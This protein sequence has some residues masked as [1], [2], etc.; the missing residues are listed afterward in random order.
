[1][2]ILSIIFL[3]E[4]VAVPVDAFEADLPLL[5]RR[6]QMTPDG[7]RI[8]LTAESSGCCRLPTPRTVRV[9]VDL[10]DD[11]QAGRTYWM[12]AQ[13][14]ENWRA[15][16]TLGLTDGL[17]SGDLS[18]PSGALGEPA[19][20]V[21]ANLFRRL[22]ATRS[23]EGRLS[24]QELIRAFLEDH[25]PDKDTRLGCILINLSLLKVRNDWYNAL[26]LLPWEALTEPERPAPLQ[27][28]RPIVIVRTIAA[29]PYQPPEELNL[30]QPAPMLALLPRKAITPEIRAAERRARPYAPRRHRQELVWCD[31]PKPRPGVRRAH[32]RK[33]FERH[34]PAALHY[35]G[36]GA[37]WPHDPGQLVSALQIDDALLG[38]LELATQAHHCPIWLFSCFAC[39]S[40]TPGDQSE[41][42]LTSE[43]W[44]IINTF[45]SSVPAML[46]MTISISTTAA[47]VAGEAWYAALAGGA[48]LLQAAHQM[49]RALWEHALQ[50]QGRWFGDR[51]AWWI[52]AL[53]LRHPCWDRALVNHT[54]WKQ[55]LQPP[56][57]S[58][59]PTRDQ[60]EQIKA[61]F[62]RLEHSRY[63]VVNVHGRTPQTSRT[64]LLHQIAERLRAERKGHLLLSAPGD[65]QAGGIERL[66]M[67]KNVIITRLRQARGLHAHW[68]G[69][70]LKRAMFD[71]PTAEELHRRY[72]KALKAHRQKPFWVLIDDIDR[73]V[74][75]QS[76]DGREPFP[77]LS[78][79][80]LHEC[81]ET[82]VRFIVTTQN[83]EFGRQ[84][85]I[86][87]LKLETDETLSIPRLFTQPR[88]YLHS[89][90]AFMEWYRERKEHLSSR[91]LAM[92]LIADQA[93]H[94]TTMH[95][96]C[97]MKELGERAD[98]AR[99]LEHLESEELAAR[100][101]QRCQAR[102]D[103]ALVEHWAGDQATAGIR[104]D[105]R[106]WFRRWYDQVARETLRKQHN[107]LPEDLFRLILK[108]SLFE[109]PSGCEIA[110]YNYGGTA[111][112]DNALYRWWLI[113]LE[114]A[115][116]YGLKSSLAD[117]VAD[118]ARSDV[119]Y[120]ACDRKILNY[121]ESWLRGTASR[122]AFVP[123]MEEI[124]DAVHRRDPGNNAQIGAFY[125]ALKKLWAVF[126]RSS[127]H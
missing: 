47:G 68:D 77:G 124:L 25:K 78:L 61:I 49:R 40:G 115:V 37:F 91:L 90:H 71:N 98:V 59:P 58:Y 113:L 13:D 53:Y 62:E 74:E 50:H 96:Y 11:T 26:L 72:V 86:N 73:L 10:F 48:T 34:A 127:E 8:T 123:L 7:R 57:Q 66:A 45:S 76:Q 42:P 33:I 35:F 22:A 15:L 70:S 121:L 104:A 117:Y 19:R 125:N 80:P 97:E 94:E 99:A 55:R 103:R 100:D 56:G 101:G 20:F 1:M 82:Q 92:L 21:G 109:M 79:L 107:V 112:R 39:H 16:H 108:R 119:P 102:L 9:L 31:C 69:Q 52:P 41:Q 116:R 67:L 3:P 111:D 46:M 29:N 28:E 93:L 60:Q 12:L 36:H 54:A 51:H 27:I 87:V 43:R 4:C 14:A 6:E 126:E 30:E 95:A 118:L 84:L 88:P 122:D 114:S 18:R 120:T 24:A 44:S 81:G 32:L 105:I 17:T 106:A 89:K 2:D 83:P 65:G 110:D 85:Y 63:R 23:P 38:A 5:I 64:T 75:P